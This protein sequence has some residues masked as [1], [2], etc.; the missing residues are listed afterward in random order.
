MRGATEPGAQKQGLEH[1]I[2]ADA[3]FETLSSISSDAIVLIDPGGV[4]LYANPRA[5]RLLGVNAATQAACPP[6]L[7]NET[8]GHAAL[9]SGQ[10]VDYTTAATVNNGCI[11]LLC[12]FRPVEEEPADAVHL[13]LQS[14]F[15]MYLNHELR[16]PLNAI[17]GFSEMMC[18]E[19]FGSF[20]QKQY[21]TYAKHIHESGRKLM[22]ILDDLLALSVADR[23]KPDLRE[24]LFDLHE[25]VESLVP[26]VL[27]DAGDDH[28][29]LDTEDLRPIL[30]RADRQKICDVVQ[31]LLG[32]CLSTTPV[33]GRVS[34]SS[35]VNRNGQALIR[36][37][38]TG[39]GFKAGELVSM[40]RMSEVELTGSGTCIGLSIALV[41]RYIEMHGGAVNIDSRQGE[42]T[43]FTCVIP[44]SRVALGIN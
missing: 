30:L 44:S 33:D 8:S 2:P 41:R 37:K 21:R 9:P 1:L 12:C 39:K 32:T 15:M 38:D 22:A 5:E 27:E 31:H 6:V 3:R 18:M 34:V 36:I 42:G 16:T 20:A 7:M 25:A 24:S 10:L 11:A 26:A 28:P 40:Q 4:I 17:L 35:E 23:D 29:V 19:L 14:R 43:I 13:I